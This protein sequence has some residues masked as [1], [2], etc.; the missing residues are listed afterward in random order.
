M[1]ITQE[2]AEQRVKNLGFELVSEFKGTFKGSRVDVRCKCGK[3][4]N[5][6]WKHLTGGHTK[7]CGCLQQPDITG[8]RFGK[9]V[10]LQ[11]IPKKERSYGGRWWLCQCDCGNTKETIYHSLIS[12]ATSSCGCSRIGEG[13]PAW[14]GYKLISGSTW[15]QM[16]TSAEERGLEF[17]ITKE[18]IYDL[19]LKQNE[20]CVLS[21]EK[22]ILDE[23]SGKTASLDRIDSNKGYVEGNV[24]WVHKDLNTMKWDFSMD[25]FTNWCKKVANYLTNIKTDVTVSHNEN[26]TEQNTQTC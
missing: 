4:F 8:K 1:R 15:V 25:E 20:K 6:S 12:G 21:G 10:V 26:L 18:Y 3:I 9:L 5:V 13:N 14:K 11:R 19:F 17:S 7:S 24:Q 16:K 2:I 23:R 22:L